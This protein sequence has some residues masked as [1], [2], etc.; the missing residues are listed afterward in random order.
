MVESTC[1]KMTVCSHFEEGQTDN[2][3]SLI[4][5]IKQ[6]DNASSTFAAY[7]HHAI[8]HT[9]TPILRLSLRGPEPCRCRG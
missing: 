2:Q 3:S 6:Q 5:N 8:L 7:R 1:I 4:R 9:S